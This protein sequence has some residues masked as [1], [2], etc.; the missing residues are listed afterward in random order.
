MRWDWEISDFNHQVDCNL[1]LLPGRSCLRSPRRSASLLLTDPPDPLYGVAFSHSTQHPNRIALTSYL[2]GPT[3]K[4]F[5]VDA[6]SSGASLS[7][8]QRYSPSVDFQ[9][10]SIAN[11]AYP[12]TKVGWEPAESLAGARHEGQGGRGELLATT[13]DVLR[14]WELKSFDGGESNR[15]GYGRNGYNETAREQYQLQE[16]SV[17]SNVSPG[18]I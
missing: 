17:L 18:H 11:L 1:S 7:S 10:L 6:P 9:Q 5:V 2:A 4:L 12:A 13:G 16:R 8:S 15:I 14:I 3:N